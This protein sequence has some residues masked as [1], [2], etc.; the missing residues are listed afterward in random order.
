[1]KRP[2]KPG[3]PFRCIACSETGKN[4][5]GNPCYPCSGLGT[6]RPSEGDSVLLKGKWIQIQ[7]SE[8]G[9]VII[10]TK[11][12]KYKIPLGKIQGWKKG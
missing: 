6:L 5:K 1:M 12:K 10:K 7:G 4:S 9:L 2:K 11:N 3:N 8:S